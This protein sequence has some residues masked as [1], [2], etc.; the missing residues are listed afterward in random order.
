MTVVVGADTPAVEHLGA[1]VYFCCTGCRQRFE[2][3]HELARRDG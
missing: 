1:T 2:E 3:R